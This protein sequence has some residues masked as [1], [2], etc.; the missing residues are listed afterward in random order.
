[1]TSASSLATE[2][3]PEDVQ[4]LWAFMTGHFGSRVISKHN[5]SEM[6]LIGDALARLGILDREAFLAN[7]TTTLR[8]G[9]YTPFEIGTPTPRWTL[10]AQVAVCIHEHQ[11]VV[12]YRRDGWTFELEYLLDQASRAAYEAEAYRTAFE[13]ENWRFGETRSVPHALAANLSAYACHSDDIRVAETYLGLSR[14]TIAAGGVPDESARVA[15][16]WLDA[17]LP[18]LKAQRG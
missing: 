17:H 5:A 15:I 1:V 8:E 16:A 10:H 3:Q 11:H 18:H 7:Y 9:I 2:F 13:L 6:R 12:Q 14:I 4:A